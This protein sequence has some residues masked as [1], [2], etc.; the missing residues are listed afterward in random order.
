MNSFNQLN[1]VV[2]Y[3]ENHLEEEIDYLELEKIAQCTPKQLPRIFVFVTGITLSEYIRKRRLTLA[4]EDI[5]KTTLS[6]LAIA[7]K[8]GYDSQAAFSRAF[9]E[10]HCVS[11]SMLRK[12]RDTQVKP[13]PR[14]VFHE[15]AMIEQLENYRVV[16]GEVKKAKVVYSDFGPLEACKFVGK[17]IRAAF[18][19]QSISQHWGRCFAEKVFEQLLEHE[20]FILEESFGNYIGYVRDVD[21]DTGMFTYVIGLFMQLDAPIPEGFSVYS[22]P[23]CTLAKIWVQGEDYDVFSSG[24]E[25]SRAEISKQGY[26]IDEE[27]YFLCE[28]YTDERYET[29]KQKGETSAILDYYL[30]VKKT[31]KK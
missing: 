17:E 18:M 20:A 14:I 5:R 8:Y 31:E 21:H 23:S 13:Y 15:E 25:L 2:V 1:Q 19:S 7:V 29:P 12:N 4:A 24:P 22:V 11:P 3:I 6:L 27:N 28:V 16:E 10:Q 30:P 26:E 9:K